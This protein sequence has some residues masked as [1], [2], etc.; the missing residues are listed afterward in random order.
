[1]PNVGLGRRM[2]VWDWDIGVHLSREEVQEEACKE[3]RRR[4]RR[5]EGRRRS[6]IASRQDDKPR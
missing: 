3:E 5:E 4:R 2:E 1:M 6:R